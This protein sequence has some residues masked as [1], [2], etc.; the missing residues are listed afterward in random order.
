LTSE[1]FAS[2][3]TEN[4]INEFFVTGANAIA[5]VKSTAINMTKEGY[6][7]HVISDCITSYD[8]KK[9][10]EMLLFYSQKGCEVKT[11]AEIMNS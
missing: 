4:N 6:K 9:I 11:L 7:V 10:D 2:F 5:C 1:P 3:I 8:L